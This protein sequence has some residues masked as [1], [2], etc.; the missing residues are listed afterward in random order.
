MTGITHTT[1]SIE[2]KTFRNRHI[3]DVPTLLNASNFFLDNLLKRCTI[4]HKLNVTIKLKNGPVKDAD[5]GLN[6][7]LAWENDVVGD[8]RSFTVHINDQQSFLEILS[9]LA[10][11]LTHVVQFATGRLRFD[12]DDWIWDGKNFGP[13]P[14]TGDIDVDCELPWE[15]DAYSK[16]PE[17]ARKF[18]KHY[19]SIW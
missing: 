2:I 12:G 19:Y 18:T 17:L 9:T 14:Y 4:G 10:H 3:Q 15:Y 13:T 16:E 1:H 7:G 6:E 5:H 8:T 11:E